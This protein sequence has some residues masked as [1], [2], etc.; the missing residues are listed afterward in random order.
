[1]LNKGKL[2]DDARQ[3]LV[4]ATYEEITR[5]EKI[6]SNLLD[7]T[8]LESGKL[9]LNRDYYFVPELVG[10]TIKRVQPGKRQLITLIGKDLPAVWVD[11]LLIEQVLFNLLENAIKYTPD[12]ATI[13]VRVKQVGENIRVQVEDDGKG[14]SPGQENR[15]FDKFY[16]L[17]DAKGKKSSGLGLAICRG[18][19]K[20]HESNITVGNRPE[21]GAIFTFDLPVKALP[22]EGRE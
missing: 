21:G 17:A 19:M 4:S 10:N 1:M 12:K 15:I 22:K 8:L 16:S 13:V 14:I 11:G 2:T 20:A 6:V 5:L 18:I 7:I 3:E 9:T